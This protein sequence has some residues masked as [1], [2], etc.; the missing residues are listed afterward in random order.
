MLATLWPFVFLHGVG[1]PEVASFAAQYPACPFPCQ[2]FALALA[3]AH[4]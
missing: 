2:H 1:V 3:G 4:A